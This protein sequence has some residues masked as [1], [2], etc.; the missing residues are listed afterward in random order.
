M[1]RFDATDRRPVDKWTAAPRPTTSP[2]GQKPQQKRSTHMVHKPVNS[3]CSRQPC[4]ALAGQNATNVKHV[5]LVFLNNNLDQIVQT[6]NHSENAG[7]YIAPNVRIKIAGLWTAMLFMFAYVDIFA[8]FRAD[9]LNG[10]LAGTVSV[11][12]IDQT[13]LLITTVYIIL[14][15]LMVYLS[16]VL[17]TNI[18]RWANVILALLYAVSIAASCIG[19]T[20]YFYLLGSFVEVVLLLVLIRHAWRWR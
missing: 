16:L 14:P 2:Q 5:R 12:T 13:F 4:A 9:I 15:V 11:F 3:E 10:I 18:N 19:E 17:P 7:E 6:G 20:W 8:L 1:T